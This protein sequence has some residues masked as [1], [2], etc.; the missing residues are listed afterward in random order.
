MKCPRCGAENPENANF[1]SLCYLRFDDPPSR[2]SAEDLKQA[3]EERRHGIKVICPNCQEVSPISSEYCIRCGF[4]F[5]DRESLV[6]TDEQIKELAEKKEESAHR[7][8]EEILSSPMIVKRGE[9]GPQ[10]M[11]TIERTLE[12]G[13]RARLHAAGRDD[14]TYAIKLIALINQSLI[15]KDKSLKCTIFLLEEESILNLD[16]LKVEMALELS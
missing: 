15:K 11:R 5:E 9:E 6:I 13:Y 8:R 1:C 10:L 3:I 16:D 4:F 14:I 12:E 2:G 7:E